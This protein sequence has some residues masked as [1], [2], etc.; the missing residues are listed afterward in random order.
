MMGRLL[1]VQKIH[2][3]IQVN[4]LRNEIDPCISNYLS[5]TKYV[6]PFITTYTQKKTFY[7]V[8]ETNGI[9]FTIRIGLNS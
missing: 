9:Q 8:N 6:D 4:S 2:K 3:V 1:T 7:D 5:I